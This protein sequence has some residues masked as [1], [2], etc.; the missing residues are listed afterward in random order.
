M[1]TQ[2]QILRLQDIGVSACH[3]GAVHEARMIFDGLLALRPDNAAAHIGKALSHIVVDDFQTAE[4]ALRDDFLAKHPDDPEASAVLGLCYIL[5]G[6]P[7]EAR[8]VLDKVAAGKDP[9]GQLARDLL[10]GLG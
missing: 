1:L 5:S 4:E 9:S 7:E 10:A 8:A 2:D 6:R 3:T